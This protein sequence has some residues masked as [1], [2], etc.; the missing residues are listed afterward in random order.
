MLKLREWLDDNNIEWHDSSDGMSTLLKIQLNE[1]EM[2]MCRTHFEID[3][4]HSR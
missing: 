4:Y 1:P 2:W 3:G